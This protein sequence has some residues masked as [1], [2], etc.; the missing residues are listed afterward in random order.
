MGDGNSGCQPMGS[1]K[2]DTDVLK[3]RYQPSLSGPGPLHCERQLW[4]DGGLPVA[5][6]VSQPWEKL[7]H[8]TV[9]NDEETMITFFKLL[10]FD[11]RQSRLVY[12]LRWAWCSNFHHEPHIFFLVSTFHD[13]QSST[14][15]GYMDP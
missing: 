6:E 9:Q 10:S 8:D 13:W 12:D 2:G 15:G 4:D 7:G 11:S 14:H 5:V 1:R 3:T